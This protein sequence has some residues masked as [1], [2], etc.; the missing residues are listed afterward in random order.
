M[1]DKVGT[2]DQISFVLNGQPV[3]PNPP[4]PP[5]CPICNIDRTVQQCPNPGPSCPMLAPA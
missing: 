2:R 4:N 1:K 3:Q 5:L